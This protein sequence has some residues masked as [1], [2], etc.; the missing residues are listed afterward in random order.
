MPL[1]PDGD[2]TDLHTGLRPGSR[3]NILPAEGTD[4][5]P[6]EFHEPVILGCIARAT[7]GTLHL[8]AG[9]TGSFPT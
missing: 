4:L 8:C 2:F 3:Y 5:G 9:I 7:Q 1:P 6:V